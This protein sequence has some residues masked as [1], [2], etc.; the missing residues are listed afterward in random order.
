MQ[1]ED[2][3]GL[4]GTMNLMTK[5]SEITGEPMSKSI[6]DTFALPEAEEG[7][8]D[9]KFTGTGYDYFKGNKTG[10]DARIENFG[11]T[12]MANITKAGE[13]FGIPEDAR[14][15]LSDLRVY[16]PSDTSNL[17]RSI[18]AMAKKNPEA[19]FGRYGITGKQLVELFDQP[20]FKAFLEQNPGQAYDANFQDFLAFES[21][22]F[23]LNKRNSI[24]GMKI[25]EGQLQVTDMTVFSPTEIEA[26]KEI[27]PRLA[28][29]KFSQLNMLAKPIAD[30]ILTDLEKAQKKDAEEGGNENVKAFK[31]QQKQKKIEKRRK[32]Q[33]LDFSE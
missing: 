1:F 26:M 31:E 11:Y 18:Y 25:E 10:L 3:S 12:I 9:S 4:V 17:P 27:F 19:V 28:N 23:Q 5:T 15:Q 13:A 21:I 32:R 8:T 29:Y 6:L 2:T 33:R 20:A 14:V 16:D 24:R 30:I 22:R 7:A